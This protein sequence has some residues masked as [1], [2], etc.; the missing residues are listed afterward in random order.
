MLIPASSLSLK[1]KLMMG[2]NSSERIHKRIAG[3]ESMLYERVRRGTRGKRGGRPKGKPKGRPHGLPACNGPNIIH[4][5][6]TCCSTPPPHL[7]ARVGA[8]VIDV[9]RRGREREKEKDCERCAAAA[10]TSEAHHGPMMGQD[11]LEGKSTMVVV[12]MQKT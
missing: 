7:C 6:H 1:Y 8:E 3:S 10:K 9:K 11:F 12:C 2:W 5:G 4:D